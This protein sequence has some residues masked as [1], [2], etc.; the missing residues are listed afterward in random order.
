M[1]APQYSFLLNNPEQINVLHTTFLEKLT[2]NF[3][4]FQSAQ[5]LLLK[6]LYVQNSFKYNNQLKKTASQTFDR[7]VLFE[8]ITSTEFS[9]IQK[10][11]FDEKQAKIKEIIVNNIEIV[12]EKETE[13]Q[14]VSSETTPVYNKLEQS[15]RNS[16]PLETIDYQEIEFVKKETLEK[17]LNIGKPLEFTATEKHSFEE[18]LQLSSYKPINREKE[19]AKNVISI[20]VDSE[21]QKKRHIIDKFIENNPKIS[22]I[23]NYI[24]T[25]NVVQ[26]TT[27]NSELMT[28][29]L[30][31][32]YLEQKK[33]TKAIQAYEILILKYPEK[34]SYFANRISDIK[35][36][37]QNNN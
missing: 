20:A 11:F 32:V 21:I 15:I 22:P 33:Y 6:N 34:F 24:P 7:D 8:F 2:A 31:K 27:D 17:K 30:A 9:A 26:E 36:L 3:P 19:I 25:A 37:Q 12:S 5:A 4:Y 35:K 13:N 28:E 18:W 16:I 1:N 10:Q 14:E 29:T 23:K